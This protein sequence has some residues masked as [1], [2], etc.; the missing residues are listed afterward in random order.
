MRFFCQADVNNKPYSNSLFRYREE[1][2][3]IHEERWNSTNKK[4]EQTSYLTRLLT[5]GDCT[6]IEI[7]AESAKN[8]SST[9][10]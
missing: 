2:A 7:S 1:G 4:W 8:L 6:L 9:Q 10:E 3:I 5:G